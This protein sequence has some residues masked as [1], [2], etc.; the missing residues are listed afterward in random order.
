MI[1]KEEQRTA[2]QPFWK[3]GQQRID[4]QNKFGKQ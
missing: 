3:R 2:L 1:E 4:T